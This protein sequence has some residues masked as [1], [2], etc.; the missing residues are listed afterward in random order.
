MNVDPTLVKTL[1]APRVVCPLPLP[2]AVNAALVP[3]EIVIAPV[4]ERAIV[5]AEVRVKE[6]AVELKVTAAE[7][8]NRGEVTEVEWTAKG[9]VTVPDP[10]EAVKPV[11]VIAPAP[12]VPDVLR[13]SFPKLIVP[14]AD[15]MLLVVTVILPK[16][17]EVEPVKTVPETVDVDVIAPDPM[18][19][20]KVA[21]VPEKL[22]AVEFSQD[23]V[24]LL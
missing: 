6:E 12:K 11:P 22:R 9:A 20:V 19:P 3:V 24:T 13:L 23:L 4:G 21:A 5:V 10:P 15:V 2:L 1:E 16:T 14:P 7:L 8:V 18:V 17:P